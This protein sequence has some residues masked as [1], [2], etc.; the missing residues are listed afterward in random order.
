MSCEVS[1]AVFINCFPTQLQALKQ[2][3]GPKH[4]IFLFFK[5]AELRFSKIEKK[6]KKSIQNLKI[7]KGV[8]IFPFKRVFLLVHILR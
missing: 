4:F 8:V 3:V 5:P 6:I 1:I 7:K 2:P